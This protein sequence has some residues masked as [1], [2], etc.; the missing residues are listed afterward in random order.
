MCKIFYTV[1]FSFESQVNRLND[2][3]WVVHLDEE[4]V[5]TASSVKGIINFVCNGKH[6]FGQGLITYAH[7][8]VS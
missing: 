1:N 5:L 6:K 4:T 3:D 2:D 7:G 8:K